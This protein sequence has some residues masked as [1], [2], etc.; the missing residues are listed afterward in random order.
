MMFDALILICSLEGTCT[1]VVS[2]N[3]FNTGQQCEAL[4]QQTVDTMKEDNP[5]YQYTFKCINW[6]TTT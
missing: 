2:P 1:S 5:E 6:G 3:F 4:M